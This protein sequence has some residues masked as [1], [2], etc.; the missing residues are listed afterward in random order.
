MKLNDLIPDFNL[1]YEEDIKAENH[2]SYFIEEENYQV[3]IVRLIE[4]YDS[5]LVYIS[6]SFI[7]Y[8]EN[9]YSYERDQNELTLIEAGIVGLYQSLLPMYAKNGQIIDGYASEV[10]QLEDS[11][12]NREIPYYFMDIWFETKKDLAKIERYYNR[13]LDVLNSFYKKKVQG[14]EVAESEIRDLIETVSIKRNIIRS[15]LSKL[16]SLHHYY[17]SVKNDRLNKN[18][19]FLTILSAIFL[20]LN[21]VVGFFGMNTEGLFFK[22]YPLGTQK[23]LFI[24]IGTFVVAILGVKI[25]KVLDNY[26]FKSFFHKYDLYKNISKK[27]E[28]LLS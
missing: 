16:D 27:L 26:I 8:K 6:S 4:I 3:L 23:V 9:I 2:P 1:L 13:N 14:R 25:V 10:D 11:L 21:L 12:Y 19:Y 17:A 15:Q 24:L 18:I 28:N 22:D 7:F 20:P 5:S